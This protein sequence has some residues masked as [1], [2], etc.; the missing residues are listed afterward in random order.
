MKL[1]KHMANSPGALGLNAR[2]GPETT[3]P[4]SKPMN[5]SE[6]RLL[7]NSITYAWLRSKPP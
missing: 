7:I 3:Q 1:F 5:I 4:P 2:H 6:A